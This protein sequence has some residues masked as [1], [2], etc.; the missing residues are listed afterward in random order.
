MSKF[1]RFTITFL[2][3]LCVSVPI[4]SFVAFAAEYG[5]GVAAFGHPGSGSSGDPFY[6]FPFRDESGNT[7]VFNCAFWGVLLSLVI[8]TFVTCISTRQSKRR[9]SLL[10]SPQRSGFKRFGDQ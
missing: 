7:I 9:E 4:A 10:I 8:A 2:A 3:S 6:R 1:G 5:R